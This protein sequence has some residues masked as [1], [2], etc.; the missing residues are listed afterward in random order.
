MNAGHRLTLIGIGA[1]VTIAI[2]NGNCM[3][4]EHFSDLQ[5]RMT[6]LENRIERGF[7][8]AAAQRRQIIGRIER[9]ENLH[10]KPATPAGQ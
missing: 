5:A 2:V 6:S 3:A 1:V 9:L 7:S 8:E 10:L 4:N